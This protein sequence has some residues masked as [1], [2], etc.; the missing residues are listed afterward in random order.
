MKHIILLSSLLLTITISFAQKQ[1]YNWY[2]GEYAGITF[3]TDPPSALT[4]GILNTGAGC[5]SISDTSGN[6]LFYTDGST[7]FNMNHDTMQYGTGLSGN[8]YTTQS[9]VIV[10]LP[11]SNTIYYIFTLKGWMDFPAEISYSIVDMSLNGG[12]GAVT[13]KNQLILSYGTERVTVVKHTNNLN[14]WIVFHEWN[15]NLFYSF[16]LSGAGL[17]MTPIVSAVGSTHSGFFGNGAGY[18]TSNPEGNRIAVAIWGDMDIF[19]LFH[20]DNSTGIL[21]NPLSIPIDLYGS[22]GVE[23]SPSGQFLYVSDCGGTSNI[24]QY[25]VSNYDQTS[26]INSKYTIDAHYSNKGA[27]QLGPDGKIYVSIINSEYLSVINYPNNAG[28]SCS[29]VTDAL[30][31]GGK[32]ALYGLPPLID[33]K[34]YFEDTIP[35][36]DTTITSYASF[37]NIFTPNGDQYNETFQPQY[38]NIYD[39]HISVFNRWG[40]P[41]FET[42]DI[43]QVWD[44]TFK[45]NDCADGVYFFIATYNMYVNNELEKQTTKGSVTLIRN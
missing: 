41:V 19:E 37:P 23:F 13:V 34:F 40:N 32:H 39:Y 38:S 22:Y 9:A 14:F 35:E 6:I 10:P 42:N 11:N 3:N 20:F 1:N 8:F 28:A 30:Y 44:G 31:L 5:A 4:N 17:S 45:G 16:L 24:Y 7:V 12:L 43:D 36:I 27:L 26:I 29:Y 33:Q 25:D 2:F 15:S 18:M 21:S